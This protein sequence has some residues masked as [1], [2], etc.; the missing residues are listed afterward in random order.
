MATSAS[1][2][3]PDTTDDVTTHPK[4]R[5]RK[6]LCSPEEWSRHRKL[7][8]KIASAKWYAKKKQV[9]RNALAKLTAKLHRKALQV[10]CFTDKLS[11]QQQI[12]WRCIAARVFHGWPPRPEGM[13]EV[14]WCK[15]MDDITSHEEAH[16]SWPMRRIF[17]HL[18]VRAWTSPDDLHRLYSPLGACFVYLVRLGWHSLLWQRCVAIFQTRPEDFSNL[19]SFLCTLEAQLPD[20][21][22]HPIYDRSYSQSS[23]S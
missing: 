20:S 19:L 12:R 2:N 14:T 7:R 16:W 17:R 5:V 8:K 18:C 6:S 13:D 3:I 22:D 1:F 9:E 23:E 10:W 11:P 15:V 4:K 21:L